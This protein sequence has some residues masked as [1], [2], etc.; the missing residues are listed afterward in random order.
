[1]S[2]F[3]QGYFVPRNPEKYKGDPTKIRY[4]SS[5][6]YKFNVFLDGN[7]NVL[8]WASEEIA[9]PYVSPIDG[10]I[11]HY[12]PDYYICYKTKTGEIKQEIIE[13]KPD[14]QTRPPRA[15]SKHLQYEAAT[16]AVNVAKWSAAK[17]FCDANGLALKIL[18]EKQLF[19]TGK[20][21]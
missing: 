17:Q 21:K 20:S 3:K 11:H 1:M 4:M 5:W 9:I 7:P 6:E 2:R 18:T 14:K 19:P 13:I 8:E 10:R 15:N 16:Y 12:F